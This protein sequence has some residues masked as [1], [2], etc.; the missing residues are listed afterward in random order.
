MFDRH[1]GFVIRNE[2]AVAK[3][4]REQVSDFCIDDIIYRNLL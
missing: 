1:V 4:M 3:V 2:R